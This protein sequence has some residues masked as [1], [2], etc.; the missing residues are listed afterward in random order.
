L[1]A[2]DKPRVNASQGI[3]E[4]IKDFYESWLV[5]Q[6]PLD[7]A[8]YLSVKSY[9]CI[10]EFQDGSKADSPLAKARIVKQ[11]R[12]VNAVLGQIND[13]KDA[14]QG[15]ALY[16]PGAKPVKHPYGKLF[17]LELLS[18]ET[19]YEMDCRIRLKLKMAEEIPRP[20]KGFSNYYG[21]ILR[22]KSP[23]YNSMVLFQVWSKEGNEWRLVTWHF[24][25]PF[26]APNVPR[27]PSK[28]EPAIAQVTPPADEAL[29]RQTR[30]FLTAWLLQR[31]IG[32]VLA[33]LTPA[34][35]EC[36]AEELELF[37]SSQGDHQ[38]RIQDLFTQVAREAGQGQAL[39]DLLTAPDFSH[40][41]IELLQHAEGKAYILARI[42]DELS[43]MY[44]C[45]N[46]TSGRKYGKEYTQ[47]K[48]TFSRNHYASIFQLKHAGENAAALTLIWEQQGSD[49]KVI[50]F[51]IVS[52]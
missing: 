39:S 50:A 20:G 34:T 37:A 13:L 16:A 6:K 4:A 45:G 21:A 49:W 12:D 18:D 28:P 22:L 42:S 30:E 27:M 19:A 5:K 10:V 7:A 9:P 48:P 41:H 1:D 35:L 38:K 2:P 52:Y 15:V 43:A 33:Y 17:A 25:H 51:D 46:R 31:D 8:A 47:G 44:Q 36:A 26:Q 29:A 32:R 40:D 23:K 3:H 14:I 24:D 11:M